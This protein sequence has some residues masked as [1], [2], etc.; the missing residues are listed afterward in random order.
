VTETEKKK[1]GC[2]LESY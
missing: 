2:S 1:L